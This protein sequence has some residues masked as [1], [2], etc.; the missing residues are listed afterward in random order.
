MTTPLCPVTVVPHIP[1]AP[2][3][4]I[5]VA[6]HEH[7][8]V[9]V[10]WERNGEGQCLCFRKPRRGYKNGARIANGCHESTD[11]STYARNARLLDAKIYAKGLPV[12]CGEFLSVEGPFSRHFTISN[13]GSIWD[14]GNSPFLE[15]KK[16]S[17]ID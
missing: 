15:E 2:L 8:V 9:G 17:L 13:E 10:K 11:S 7:G 3:D 4:G 14:L 5:G 6:H 16:A 12:Y 1:L